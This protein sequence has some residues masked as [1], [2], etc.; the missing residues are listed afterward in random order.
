M[1]RQIVCFAIACLAASTA[2]AGPFTAEHLVRI[3]RVGAP[4][5]S[6]DGE[7]IVY[8]VRHT[9]M[10]ADKG[11]YDLW[12]SSIDG[13]EPQRLTTHEANDTSPAWTPDSEFIA[14]RK[15]F[16]TT[17]SLGTGEIW[18]YHR[19][20]GEGIQ[21]IEKP[22]KEHQ[23]ELGEPAFSPDG[24]YLYRIIVLLFAEARPELGIL[25]VDD[26]D[27]QTLLAMAAAGSDTGDAIR[28]SLR[29]ISQGDG[30]AVDNAA[31]GVRAVERRRGTAQD[32]HALDGRGRHERKILRRR[33]AEDRVVE[34]HTVDEMQHGRTLLPA[35]D[36]RALPRR[37]LLQEDAGAI[38]LDRL[39]LLGCGCLTS[40]CAAAASTCFST[41]GRVTGALT[42]A[43]ST[44][45]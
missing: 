11:R 41:C 24:R 37:G 6:P 19:D 32:L 40:S 30:E 22:G 9:D 16:T 38:G 26:P 25:P 2:L 5:V 17:R 28:Q 18:M 14:A 15:H 3:D 31:D 8:A 39:R 12:L 10:D 4:A 20:G 35:H 43:T 36:R 13:G 21:I 27:Y 34:P 23:K 45:V 1:T 7:L 44:R 33:A 42:S 29:S